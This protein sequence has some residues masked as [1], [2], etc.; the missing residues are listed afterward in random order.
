MT[1][2]TCKAASTG[3]HRCFD[4]PVLDGL[5]CAGHAKDPDMR[6]FDRD[7]DATRYR[8]M[9]ECLKPDGRCH[10]SVGGV[11][12]G[13]KVE[14]CDSVVPEG[15]IACCDKCGDSLT[16]DEYRAFLAK[17]ADQLRANHEAARKRPESAAD[18]ESLGP[19][20]KRARWRRHIGSRI[21][22]GNMVDALVAASDDGAP[23]AAAQYAI[24]HAVLHAGR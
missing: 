24:L 13:K 18:F 12:V 9:I 4:K 15:E 16:C 6:A 11:G 20:G 23:P 5:L 10:G 22:G 14:R 7:V 1:S 17:E 8:F 3:N 19:D 2:S 21:E